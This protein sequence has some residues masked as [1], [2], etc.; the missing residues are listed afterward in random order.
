VAVDTR[1]SLYR[2]TILSS[3]DRCCID[4]EPEQ[5]T[6]IQFTQRLLDAGIALLTGSVGDSFDNALAENLRSTIE[7]ELIYW[8]ATIFVTR[9]EGQAALFRYTDRWCEAAWHA[10]QHHHQPATLQPEGTDSR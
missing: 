2:P 10:R 3:S 9:A 7:V 1:R 8:T 6:S 4:L 5:Y